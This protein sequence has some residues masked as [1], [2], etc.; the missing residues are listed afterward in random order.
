MTQVYG[1]ATSFCILGPLSVVH[2]GRD[3]T[4]TAPKIR[5][6]LTFLLMRRNQLVQVSELIDELW[7]DHPPESAMT[8][9]QT[10]IYKLRKDL[11]DP[12]SLGRVH[13]KPSGYLLD[14]D[15]RRIDAYDFERL[16][17]EGRLALENDDPLRATELLT[18]ALSLWRGQALV[19][20]AAGEILSAY[21]T[22]L[23]EERLRALELRIEA[24]MR[25]GHHQK[26]IS[27]LKML[28]FT[29]ALH[30]RFHADLMTALHRSG[31]RYEA[32]EVYRR[33][34]GV[35]INELGLEPSASVQRLHQSLL[36]ADSADHGDPADPARPAERAE[37]AVTDATSYAAVFTLAVPAQLPPDVPDF[38]GRVA[39]LNKVRCGLA[40]GA[41]DSTTARVVSICGMPGVGKTTLAL[42]AAHLDRA[43]YPDG[44]L[45][46]DLR[47]ASA[48]PAAPADV[49][50]G[51]LRAVGVP[52]H[53]IP[54]ATEEE[55]R[56]KLFRTW[57]YDRRVLIVLDDACTATQVASLLPST[58]RCAVIITSRW[59]LQSLPGVRALRLGVMDVAEGVEL[60]GRIVGAERVAAEREHAETIVELSGCLPLA[61]RCVGARLSANPAWS[62]RKLAALIKSGRAPLDEFRFAE[63]DVRARYDNSYS[64]LDP[65]ERS[66]LRLLSLL[67]A[68]EFSAATVAGLLGNPAD[69]V[70]A[71]FSRLVG[72]HLLEIAAHD[73]TD[74]P[75]YKLHNLSR[76]YAR[77]RLD[78]EF[79][80]PEAVGA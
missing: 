77:E 72:C 65:S 14:V 16:A 25:L 34:R 71:H 80:Q 45:F 22:R 9:L 38:T 79:I 2:D 49:L 18:E 66:T 73:G 17:S 68:H 55:E 35:L 44:Q 10:Y 63:F 19:G 24:D 6:V 61:L 5:Q 37:V 30:E 8:T 13:T 74:E 56:A 69:V 53:Q 7:G 64:Q 28:T 76:L 12:N 67:P 3:I 31:R 20:V 36:N 46:A 41:D 70:E 43:Q 11:I 51:F 50:A 62:L 57:T 42:R 39:P 4:P 26:L 40:A 60:L 27:E 15:G 78:R 75:R 23:E 48:N 33:L 21:L 29:H 47:G 32:L 58:P 59:G 52:E 1:G 54:T